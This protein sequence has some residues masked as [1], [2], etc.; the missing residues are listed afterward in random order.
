[1]KIHRDTFAVFWSRKGWKQAFHADVP[2]TGTA[3]DAA[4]TF[5]Q[6]FPNDVIRSVRDTSGRFLAFNR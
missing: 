6:L 3:K 4:D 2:A 5:R 1:M